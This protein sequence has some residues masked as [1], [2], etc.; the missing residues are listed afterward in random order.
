ML[1]ALCVLAHL[2]TPQGILEED[3]R[4]ETLI[5]SG[6]R[7]VSIDLSV[8][9][10]KNL[11]RERRAAGRSTVAVKV[12]DPPRGEG[13]DPDEVAAWEKQALAKAKAHSVAKQWLRRTRERMR[14]QK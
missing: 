6:T 14:R 13:M 12:M 11:R 2:N 8:H 7:R 9:L 3:F 5:E 4:T 10:M 1:L